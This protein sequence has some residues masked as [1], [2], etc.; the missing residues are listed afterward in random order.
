MTELLSVYIEIESDNVTNTSHLGKYSNT[1]GKNYV[2]RREEGDW[3]PGSELYF[4]PVATEP[5]D[6]MRDYQRAEAHRRY[7][8]W[9]ISIT[10][11]AEIKVLNTI[12]RIKT[13]SSGIESDSNP[14]FITLVIKEQLEKL[15]QIL[16]ELHVPL[17]NKWNELYNKASNYKVL[18]PN[19]R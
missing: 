10:A 8:W 11:I 7:K 1:P 13:G 19:S 2:C 18:N 17:D 16:Q 5:A 15:K 9:Y 4:N 6:I 3:K 14:N 12:Q